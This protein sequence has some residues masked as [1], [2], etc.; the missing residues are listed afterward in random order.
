MNVKVGTRRQVG[1]KDVGK[2]GLFG[3]YTLRAGKIW[4]ILVETTYKEEGENR[5]MIIIK[6]YKVIGR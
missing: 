3:Y 6:K 1:K 4:N 5:K 2:L